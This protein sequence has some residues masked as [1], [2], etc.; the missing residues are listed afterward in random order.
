MHVFGDGRIEVAAGAGIKGSA[1]VAL[2]RILRDGSP[3]PTF[4]SAGKLLVSTLDPGSF[5]EAALTHLL[6]PNTL[7]RLE[8]IGVLGALEAEHTRAAGGEPLEGLEEMRLQLIDREARLE[9]GESLAV[10]FTD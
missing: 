5:P 7:A 2:F 9:A 6:Y 8:E 10:V 3:D 4:G 1:N